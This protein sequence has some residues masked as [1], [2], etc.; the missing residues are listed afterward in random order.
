ML[1]RVGCRLISLA[2]R[3]LKFYPAEISLLKRDLGKLLELSRLEKPAGLVD[4]LACFLSYIPD[5]LRGR[6]R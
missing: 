2:E 4:E 5:S 1:L 3:E 6:R